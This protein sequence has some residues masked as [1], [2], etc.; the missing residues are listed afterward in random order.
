MAAT[1]VGAGCLAPSVRLRADPATA[2]RASAC[3][4]RARL[5]RLARGRYVAELSREGPAARPAQQQQLAPPLV[6]GFLAPPPP[7][8]AQ[9]PAPT[10][11]PLPDAGVGELAPDL[12]LEG[13][14]EDSIDSIIVAASEQDSEIMDANEQPQAKVTR[15][16][17]FVTGEAA[18]YAKSG[19][20]GDVCGSLPIA[21]AA[22]GHRVMV[23][24]PRYLNGSSDKNYAKALYTGKHIKIPCFGGSHEVTF[25][26]EYRDNVDWVFVD[27]PSYHRPGSLYGD[28]FGAFGDNQFRYTLLCYAA[29][30][31]PLI[32]ELGGYIYGQ[33]CMFVVNDWHASLVPVL[34]AAKYRPY[35]VYR[36]SRSTLVIHN[37]AHQGVEPA[38]TYPDLGLP[39]EWYG[40][41]EWVFPEWARR[42]ALDKGEAV[43]F[44]KGAVVTADRIV[45]VSQGYSWEVTTAEG[46]Q[47]L[48]EL[49]SSRKSVLN[50][51]V[52]GI[53]INDWN[54]TTDKCLPH[55]YSVDDLSGKAKCKAELQKEL[56][57]PVREDVPLIGFIGRLDYQKGI[58]LIKMAIPE[59]MREDVQFV[60]LGS[61]DPI[62]EGWMRSTESSYKDKFRGWVGF[63]VPVSHRITAGCDILLMP[64]RFE[65][66]GLN[67]LYAMQ[68]GTVPVVHGTGG[69]RDT[70]ETFN[71]FGAKGEEGTGWAFSPLTVDKMLWALRTAMSTFREHK[72]SWEGLMKR[73][74]TKD[75]T[76]DHAAEQ[77]EQIFEWAFVDQPYVM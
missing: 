9:S 73:G 21:L 76:W 6:P 14:A 41:L 59:L 18:P 47:G 12:L 19:G 25:F 16:I 36:D 61:G 54:P 13:I 77:Y 5:R 75:H 68:Y 40:A 42:H 23:V 70:V 46:G 22:R 55:H 52:N 32:L 2:A 39:P 4:V 49:L 11:P 62:F 34:L 67:Q 74:M 50:G 51:I 15:S 17:V 57:L 66:C 43:N 35:G 1:G 26:H 27:H 10:Q 29:C 20:L 48:N 45:T 64:S 3:V 30:E 72:P 33:N 37:L 71:P 38:S 58:D 44:L 7:A 69:L 63:S 56:G 53:D 28:N 60:M 8:P 65:P 24:M 31:A